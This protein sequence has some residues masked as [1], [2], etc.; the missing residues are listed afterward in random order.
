MRKRHCAAFKAAHAEQAAGNALQHSRMIAAFK[1][2]N[3]K[4]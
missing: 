1:G 2:C 3:H 4:S